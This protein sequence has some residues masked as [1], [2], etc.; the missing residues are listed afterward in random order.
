MISPLWAGSVLAFSGVAPGASIE[1][2]MSTPTELSGLASFFTRPVEARLD[3]AAQRFLTPGGVGFDFST[4]A[5]EAA[6]AP[7]DGVSWRVFKNPLTLFIGGVSAVLMEFADPRVRAGVWNH[8]R[9]PQDPVGRLRR[10]GLAAMATVYG[11][12]TPAEALIARIGRMH[13]QVVGVTPAGDPYRGDDPALLE[14]VHGTAAIGFLDAYC[15]FAAPLSAAERD[16]FFAEGAPAARLYGVV[17][18]VRDAADAAAL[19]AAR[20][21]RFEGS[22]IIDDFLSLMRAAPALPG[23]LRA[24]QPLLVSAAISTTPASVRTALGLGDPLSPA[25][26]GVVA[27]LTRAAERLRLPSSPPIAACRRL[28]LPDDFLFRRQP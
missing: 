12:R 25:G 26:R 28:G 27:R 3:R 15:A 23:A 6:L 14:W 17:R 7:A 10:T 22:P 13:A 20:A 5:G 21:P 8:S 1:A 19:L 9:F 11:A 2:I 16:A 24:L 18:P 4:P